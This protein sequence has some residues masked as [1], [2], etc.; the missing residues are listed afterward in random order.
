MM[1]Q[2]C[3]T[4]VGFLPNQLCSLSVLY[5]SWNNFKLLKQLPATISSFDIA[6]KLG[7]WQLYV[8]SAVPHKVRY[9]SGDTQYDCILFF[10][11][12]VQTSHPDLSANI[13][14][15]IWHDPEFP[16]SPSTS[17]SS[18]VHSHFQSLIA[19][20]TEIYTATNRKLVGLGCNRKLA[21]TFQVLRCRC[22]PNRYPHQPRSQAVPTSSI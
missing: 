18:A 2:S 12:G 20:S 19:D 17:I 5:T 8:P 6:C 22:L 16:S 3:W 21:D 9:L 15:W 1:S 13:V 14:S 7:S 11:S 4:I 10:F